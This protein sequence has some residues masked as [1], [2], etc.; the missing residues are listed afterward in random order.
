MESEAR[1]I[2]VGLATLILAALLIGGLFWLAGR[3]GTKDQERYIVYFRVQSLE[4][5]QINS[6]VRMQ[7]IKVGKVMDYAILPGEAH[8]VRVLLQVDARTPVMDGVEAVVSRHLVTGLA[9]IDL[10]NPPQAQAPLTLVPEGEKYPVIPEGVSQLAKVTD[11]LEELSKTSQ[12]ALDRFNTLLSDRNQRAFAQTLSNLD[13]VTGDLKK[14]MPEM[15]TALVSVQHAADQMDGLGAEAR[16]SLQ[17]TTT[18]LNAVLGNASATLVSSRATLVRMDQEVT[19]L[20][21]QVKLTT[22]LAGQDIQSTAQS[23]REAG[24]A[25]KDSGRALSDPARVLFGPNPHGLGPGE[26]I[27]K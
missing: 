27:R 13:S 1:Y 6:D 14:T 23:L 18:Q 4:G 5:L 19:T 17:S 22:D 3:S 24:D 25:L 8:K 26:E 2:R 12:E 10:E 16:T 7:G 21:S 9:A 15:Q 20:S 11:N